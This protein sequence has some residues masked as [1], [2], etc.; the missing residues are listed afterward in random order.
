MDLA[1]SF[2]LGSLWTFYLCA[3]IYRVA[4]MEAQRAALPQREQM[5][6][7]IK[8]RAEIFSERLHAITKPTPAPAYATV[9][10]PKP[11]AKQRNGTL[12]KTSGL[13]LQFA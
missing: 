12:P 4:A 13:R 1:I 9:A 2:V 10:H 3:V 6:D 5:L 8:A 7:A 11:R